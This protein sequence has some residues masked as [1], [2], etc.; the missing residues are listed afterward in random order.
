MKSRFFI[1]VALMAALAVS[2]CQQR[3]ARRRAA[4]ARATALGVTAIN[5]GIGAR[6]LADLLEAHIWKFEVRPNGSASK[7]LMR[8]QLVLFRKG[9]PPLILHQTV[10]LITGDEPEAYAGSHRL[11]VSLYPVDDSLSKARSIKILMR[12]DTGGI[13]RTARV[14]E[15]PFRDKPMGTFGDPIRQ[16]DGSFLVMARNSDHGFST[17][18]PN[19]EEYVA[20]RFSTETVTLGNHPL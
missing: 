15:N 4:E 2:S 17:V 7:Q 6:D 14:I 16:E 11:T 3:D 5:E 18:A 10:N 9:Q 19:N 12:L 20:I 13:I 8:H 1:I